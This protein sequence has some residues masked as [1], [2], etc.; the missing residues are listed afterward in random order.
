NTMAVR[1]A[2]NPR[3]HKAVALEVLPFVSMRDFH[4]VRRAWAQFDVRAVDGGVVI[5]DQDLRATL[6][7]TS[8]TAAVPATRG[9]ST[10]NVGPGGEVAAVTPPVGGPTFLPKP[11]WWFNHTYAVEQERG[12]DSTEDLYTPGRFTFRA[13]AKATMTLVCS[14]DGETTIDWDAEV[15]RRRAAYAVPGGASVVVRRLL[16]A[17]NDFV[18][19][20]KA[21]DGSPGTTII[22]GYPWFSDWGRDTMI[23]LPGL[24]LSTRRFAEAGNVLKTFAEFVSEG[25][26][27]NVFD[28]YSNEPH[29]NTVDASLWFVHAV[30]EYARLAGDEGRGLF[31]QVLKPACRKII[32]GYR[33]GTRFG[34]K[35]DADGLIRQDDPQLT[36]M[37]AKMGDTVFTPRAGK[38]VEINALW[39]HALRL[40]G[41]T[42][43]ADRARASFQR[44]FWVNAFRGL[45]DVVDGLPEADGQPYPKRDLSLRCNQIFA[46]S[47]PNS[48][49]TREQQQAVV[50]V[51]RRELLTP[52]G[53]RTLAKGDPHYKGRYTG[54]QAQRDAA[55]HTGTIWPW[56]VGAFLDAY[57]RVNDRGPKA[58][59]QAKL[60]LAPLID[61]M[62]ASA[63]VG[64]IS[65]IF[66]ADEPHRPV[67]CFAQAW[68]VAEVLR[69]AV[70]LGM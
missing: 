3:R 46:A 16:H 60:W 27:P 24:L 17:A 6:T 21:P 20:R 61:N 5:A 57:L 48:P 12:L 55:Y 1:Y 19:A 56:P 2:V 65:E 29:Y 53:L 9:S 43:L 34:I 63:C 28:D 14:T 8:G 50:E 47:L 66:E 70:D 35:M 7:A 58:V 36:W 30:H 26:I 44:A 42:A 23:A 15:G 22:A 40:M 33:D 32:D 31:E 39:Y 64:Q 62:L 52:V 67:G 68:S 45:A 54:P 25:M 38:A 69:L 59:D 4:A 37:D 18:V 11:D 49:L 41:E 51:V 10:G 13:T